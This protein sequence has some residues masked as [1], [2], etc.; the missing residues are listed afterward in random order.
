MKDIF[1]FSLTV[2]VVTL[3]ISTMGIYANN[4]ISDHP[5]STDKTPHALVF[6]RTISMGLVLQYNQFQLGII[7]GW[8]KASGEVGR[9]WIFNDKTWYPFSIGFNFF[10]EK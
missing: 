7:T 1:Y 3:G 9:N 4:T 8:D 5:N 6:R 2:P 10:S